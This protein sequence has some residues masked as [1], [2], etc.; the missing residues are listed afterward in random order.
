MKKLSRKQKQQQI[1][2]ALMRAKQHRARARRNRW[3]KREGLP[4]GQ[5]YIQGGIAIIAPKT[6]SLYDQASFEKTVEF[7]DKIVGTWETH[8]RTVS[9][10][11]S[12]TEMVGASAALY[13]HAR[14]SVISRMANNR[15]IFKRI[16]TNSKIAHNLDSTEFLEFSDRPANVKNISPG[17]LPITSNSGQQ[18]KDIVKILD[19]AFYE[20]RLDKL[21]A[22]RALIHVAVSEAMLNVIQH[23]YPD[24]NTPEIKK[25]GK[26]W[27]MIGQKFKNQLFLALCDTGEGIPKTI[28]KNEMWEQLKLIATKYVGKG[29]DCSLIKAAMELGESGSDRS[30][31]G[32]GLHQQLEYVA[33]NPHG[34][35]WI[36]SNHGLY[37]YDSSNGRD[38]MRDHKK[39][40]CGTII[41]WN[42]S[43]PEEE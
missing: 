34:V 28:A 14:L 30:G 31:R 2:V 3:L 6:I 20:G 10:D 1:R 40:V 18:A 27:W 29:A 8:R 15:D 4:K 26:R 19:D 22:T 25:L 9:I 32:E 43:L 7:A 36:F 41:Q 23:A 39:S 38:T 17:V 37:S 11:F 21:H 42:V 5:R 35:L 13:L 12:G 24:E 16:R 33:K